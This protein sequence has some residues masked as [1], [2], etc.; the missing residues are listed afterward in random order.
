MMTSMMFL[1]AAAREEPLGKNSKRR[2]VAKK[3]ERSVDADGKESVNPEKRCK[4]LHDTQCMRENG[5]QEYSFLLTYTRCSYSFLSCSIGCSHLT[6]FFAFLL[7]FLFS[8]S[9]ADDVL[10]VAGTNTHSDG[11]SVPGN[12]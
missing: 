1:L 3:G 5:K 11:L 9:L 10:F 8:L 6:L 7:V 12:G 4:E 2:K